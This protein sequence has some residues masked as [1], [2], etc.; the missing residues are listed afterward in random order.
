[1]VIFKQTNADV[2]T[3]MVVMDQLTWLNGGSKR[4]KFSFLGL[5]FYPSYGY[6]NVNAVIPH[7]N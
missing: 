4:S 3:L 1:M 6:G 7:A 2:F 5:L